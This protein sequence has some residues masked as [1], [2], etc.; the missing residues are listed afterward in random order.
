MLAAGTGF[1]LRGYFKQQGTLPDAAPLP[2]LAIPTTSGT[3]S[4]VTF[5]TVWDLPE[6]IFL[7]SP[8]FARAALLDRS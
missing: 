8:G 2:L 6:K 4:E 7:A 5:A 3:G 1:S